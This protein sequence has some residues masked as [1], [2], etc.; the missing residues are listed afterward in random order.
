[1]IADALFKCTNITSAISG[2]PL[3]QSDLKRNITAKRIV[4]MCNYAWAQGRDVKGNALKYSLHALIPFTPL[5]QSFQGFL[6][7]STH[8]TSLLILPSGCLRV[9]CKLVNRICCYIKKKLLPDKFEYIIITC[10][11]DNVMDIIRGSYMLIISWISRL[12][13]KL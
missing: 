2:V 8:K 10:L 4:A 13:V 6:D 7:P 9:P 5:L 12:P 11:L 3:T 1:M